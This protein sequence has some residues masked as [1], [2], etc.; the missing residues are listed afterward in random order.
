MNLSHQ[1][2][3][4]TGALRN[5]LPERKGIFQ[6]FRHAEV[7]GERKI[8]WVLGYEGEEAGKELA[9]RDLQEALEQHAHRHKILGAPNGERKA[10]RAIP[11]VVAPHRCRALVS[12]HTP[13]CAQHFETFRY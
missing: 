5:R 4:V 1:P 13:A 2:T 8:T 11:K 7:S 6:S 12:L 9:V 10:G 3:E